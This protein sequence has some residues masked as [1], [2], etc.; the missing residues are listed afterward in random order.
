MNVSCT[1]HTEP[2]SGSLNQAETN[3]TPELHSLNMKR[4]H[5][6]AQR[7]CFKAAH[8]VHLQKAQELDQKRLSVEAE[9]KVL[10]TQVHQLE[11]VTV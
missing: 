10:E 7:E 1:S 3:Q 2:E 8:Q 11:K 5:L 4:V 9:L 6:L